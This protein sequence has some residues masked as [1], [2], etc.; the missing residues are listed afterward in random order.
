MEEVFQ[1]LMNNKE[2]MH[3][4]FLPVETTTSQEA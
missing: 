4:P 1:S 3:A 2:S